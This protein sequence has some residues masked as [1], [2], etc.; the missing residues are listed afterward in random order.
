MHYASMF[1]FAIS[2]CSICSTD[3]ELYQS[4]LA[5]VMLTNI[6]QVDA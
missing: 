3:F 5:N 4:T 6:M 2:L 1:P